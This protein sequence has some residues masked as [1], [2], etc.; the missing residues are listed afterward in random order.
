MFETNMSINVFILNMLRICSECAPN[1][2][3]RKV[4]P[5][6]A[7]YWSNRGENILKIL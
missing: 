4:G 6:W 2:S 7:Q 5:I 3:M 1:I